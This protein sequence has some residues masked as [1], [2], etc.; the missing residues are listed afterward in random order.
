MQELD[1]K[2]LAFCCSGRV[3]MSEM[4]RHFTFNYEA[5]VALRQILVQ[6]VSD[7]KQ[8]YFFLQKC[9]FKIKTWRLSYE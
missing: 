6:K 1:K 2:V 5:E 9:V 8:T 4:S 7:K 3:K